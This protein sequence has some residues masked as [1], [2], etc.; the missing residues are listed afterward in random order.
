MNQSCHSLADID[1]ESAG[2][3]MPL[4]VKLP[5][6]VLIN[7]KGLFVNFLMLKSLSSLSPPLQ[8]LSPSFL[9]PLS[10]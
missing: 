8:V 7:E 1:T 9:L 5:E 3:V 4:I 10:L 2:T 6:S